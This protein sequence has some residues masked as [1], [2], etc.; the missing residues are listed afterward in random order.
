MEAYEMYQYYLQ[1]KRKLQRD[2]DL[3][4]ISRETDH[5]DSAIEKAA[6][7]LL[8]KNST[9]SPKHRLPT[10]TFT[11]TLPKTSTRSSRIRLYPFFFSSVFEVN[12][13]HCLMNDL[14]T[15]YSTRL[16]TVLRSGS[17]LTSITYWSIQDVTS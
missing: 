3:K 1:A 4:H 15:L 5:Y 6:I 7:Q 12:G 8:F 10:K 17:T 11:K 13:L 2:T 9:I 16:S 14:L